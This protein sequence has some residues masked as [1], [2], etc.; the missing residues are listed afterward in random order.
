[1]PTKS[2]I[3]NEKRCFVCHCTHGLERHHI[4]NG[5]GM[6]S[7]SEADGLWIWLCEEH[8][9]AVTEC[10][11]IRRKLKEMGQRVYEEQIGTRQEFRHRYG[12]YY[13]QEE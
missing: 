7:K 5:S 10:F 11:P 9:R 6:R 1:M 3:D 8:H 4:F 13:I 2:R 12:K